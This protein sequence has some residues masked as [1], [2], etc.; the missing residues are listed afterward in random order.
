MGSV[1]L[2]AMVA[3]LLG[4]V[5][6]G[7]AV[8]KGLF[9][10][11]GP[12]AE[13]AQKAAVRAGSLP[14][15]APAASP[16]ALAEHQND[17]EGRMATLEERL[18][19]LNA[20]AEAAS[21]NAARAE[22]LL[23]AFAARRALDRG[24]PLGYLEDQLRLRFGN[25]QPNAVA[26][27]IAAAKAPVTVDQLLAGLDSLAPSLTETPA[28]TGAWDRIKREVSGLFVIRRD[29]TPSPA[30]QMILG[31]ARILLTAGRTDDA[32]AELRRLPGAAGAT[33]WF[34]AARRYDDAHRALDVLETTAVL[35]AHALRDAGGQAAAQ[36]AAAG[37]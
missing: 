28:N 17:I 35:D 1:L 31:R 6:V 11:P 15:S 4:A 19:T 5:V 24:A 8:V 21:G 33:D 26:T 16:A 18:D 20:E 29:A 34:A 10:L 27:V 32:V 13:T 2:A 9:P 12:Q 22:S 30:P 36:P 7:L 14:A 3:F 23:I 37:D 25:A